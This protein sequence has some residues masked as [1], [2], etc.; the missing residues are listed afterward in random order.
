MIYNIPL[1]ETT[2]DLFMGRVPP[3]SYTTKVAYVVYR[4]RTVIIGL[5]YHPPE[6]HPQE[7][8]RHNYVYTKTN[9]GET[10]RTLTNYK[11]FAVEIG[12][13]NSFVQD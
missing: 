3:G 1:S 6:L 13:T 5:F 8:D 10:D 7:M 4:T 9:C 11:L 2:S 12:V